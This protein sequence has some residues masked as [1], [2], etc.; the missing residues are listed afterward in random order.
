[1]RG[2]QQ[3]DDCTAQQPC[4]NLR[5]RH[6]RNEQGA[7]RGACASPERK[8]ARTTG[9][10]CATADEWLRERTGYRAAY[11][12][13]LSAVHRAGRQASA[14]ALGGTGHVDGLTNIH[15]PIR[16]PYPEQLSR[17]IVTV[18]ALSSRQQWNTRYSMPDT[19]S[20]HMLRSS[21]FST[22]VGTVLMRQNDTRPLERP[23]H[24]KVSRLLGAPQFFMLVLHLC[25]CSGQPFFT[26]SSLRQ[27]A[28]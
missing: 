15:I 21:D 7:M 3:G 28:F 26:N 9:R 12:S 25:I 2:R 10:R 18:T 13:V 1:M 19:G 4:S 6:D 20:W 8:L 16:Q 22:E 11:V 17:G 5:T 23:S 14:R 27:H 24:A